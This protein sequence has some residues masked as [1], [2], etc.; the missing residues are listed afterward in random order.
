MKIAFVGK[1]GSG[2]STLA[3]RM[4]EHILAKGFN[5]LAVDADHNMDLAYNLEPTFSGPFLG[6]AAVDMQKHATTLFSLEPADPFTEKYAPRV[7]NRLRLMVSGP[8]TEDVLLGKRCS[9]SLS[10][11]LKI[12]LPGLKLRPDETV[13]VDEK[14]GSDGVGTGILAG[15]DHVFVIAEPTLHSIK[16]AHQ[17]SD[18]LEF[19]KIPYSFVINKAGGPYLSHPELRDSPLWSFAGSASMVRLSESLDEKEFAG[20]EKMLERAFA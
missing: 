10:S 11:P 2:K 15:F 6:E 12:Y 17:I 14:A 13:I 7:R 9:H 20:M 3:Y 19:Y 8:H 4:T 1:G 18:I 5:V 16:A